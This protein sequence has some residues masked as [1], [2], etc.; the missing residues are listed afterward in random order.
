M[1]QRM[2]DCENS[3]HHERNVFFLLDQLIV[4]SIQLVALQFIRKFDLKISYYKPLYSSFC[5][6]SSIG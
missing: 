3:T 6:R 1:S 4:V 5:S 2:K